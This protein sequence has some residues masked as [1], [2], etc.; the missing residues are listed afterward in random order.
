VVTTTR[1]VGAL[2]VIVGVIAYAVTTTPTALLP[3]VLGVALLVL[4]FVASRENLRPLA[5]HTALVLALLG[6][7]GT[8][9]NVG[10]IP[11]LLAGEADRPVAVM[12]SLVT[13]VVCAVYVALGV[14]SFIAARRAE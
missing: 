14:R 4:G 1:I 7:L 11:D 2:L 13:A 5:I 12:A 3:A 6:L 9:R 10:D 8:L